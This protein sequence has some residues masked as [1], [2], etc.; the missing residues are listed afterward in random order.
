M[1]KKVNYNIKLDASV[2]SAVKKAEQTVEQIEQNIKD[3]NSDVIAP[4]VDTTGIDKMNKQVQKTGS[5]FSFMKAGAIGAIIGIGAVVAKGIFEF[6]QFGNQIN[7][8]N[9]KLKTFGASDSE[10][11]GINSDLLALKEQFGDTFDENEILKS[12][13]S[14]QT[15]YGG[16]LEDAVKKVREVTVATNG[17]LQID[18]LGEYASQVSNV[19]DLMSATI[20]QTRNGLFTDKALDTLKEAGLRMGDLTTGQEDILKGFNIDPNEIKKR[21]N[22]GED[23]GKAGREALM[24]DLEKGFETLYAETDASILKKA[25]ESKKIADAKVQSGLAMAKLMKTINSLW[26]S[27]KLKMFEALTFLT[28]IIEKVNAFL[29]DSGNMSQIWKGMRFIF[30]MIVTHVTNIWNQL[31]RLFPI[32]Q[33]IFKPFKELAMKVFPVL[34]DVFSTILD[35]AVTLFEVVDELW[36]DLFGESIFQ[37]IADFGSMFV[38]TFS[39]I[40]GVVKPILGGIVEALGWIFQNDALDKLG[41]R[42]RGVE[43]E[44][45]KAQNEDDVKVIAKKM[46]IE[47]N[48]NN[49]TGGKG[50]SDTD[51]D[52]DKKL[53]ANISNSVQGATSEVKNITLN[54]G[55]LQSIEVQNINGTVSN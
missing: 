32:V 17:M 36:E 6:A 39:M 2:T 29:T 50:G 25:E 19:N 1:S 31:S 11:S 10:L 33:K 45:K 4:K 16:S 7:E 54:L 30:E 15:N 52:I 49:N 46:E 5:S 9:K 34:E 53:G 40:W 42:L 35:V 28:P 24:T 14:I 18:E 3:I 44:I 48:I 23:L 12:A 41:D 47:E 37:S 26:S 21:I 22:N 8:T 38:D 43:D 27:A 55:S 51:K 13:K 20:S